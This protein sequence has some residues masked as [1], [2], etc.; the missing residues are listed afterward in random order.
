[1]TTQFAAA[2][3][4]FT[5]ADPFAIGLVFIGFA[6]FAAVGAL[7]HE[8]E[9]AFSASLIYLLLGCGAAAVINV[10]GFAWVDPV[11]DAA[12]IDH[13]TEIAVIIAL[14]SAG[15]KLDRPLTPRAWGTTARLLLLA[16]PLTI[17]LI[18][19]LGSLLL[20]LS[21]AGALLLG[22]ILAPT[23]PVLAGDIGVGPPG[24]ED[25]HEPNFAL[26]SEA[27]LNDGLAFPFVLAAL[28]MA[29]GDGTE[30][31]A[32]WLAGDVL[33]AIAGGL[34]IGTA[35]GLVAAW[36]VKRLR[37]HDLLAPAFDQ[38]HALATVLIIYG[39]AEVAGT[40]GFLA[41]FAGGLAFRRYEKD[42]ELNGRVHEGAELAEKLLELSVILLLGSLLTLTGLQVPGWE[43]WLLAVL[44]LVAVRPLACIAALWGSQLDGPEEKS[45]VAW[46][47]VRGVGSLFY[48]AIA[49]EADVLPSGELDLVVWTVIVAVLVS[50]VVHGM[51]AG[52]SLRRLL[53]PRRAARRR[54]SPRP[55]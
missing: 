16:M 23:D 30:W 21:A 44:V 54:S 22:A 41:A 46:F 33:Y 2:D 12:L 5:F 52:P 27:G 1:M 17:G 13:L 34:A 51:T 35:V 28:A 18:A 20:G 53:R 43:G 14:F 29:A 15:L 24:D 9:R 40:Y 7:S 32:E 39:V 25:E 50:I 47:G 3:I 37:D 49:V 6:I 11:E 45:F 42:H 4:G 38:Y 8:R 26:T 55:R 19:L 48:L 31:V 10:A 36:S